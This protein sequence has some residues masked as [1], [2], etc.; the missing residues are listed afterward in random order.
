MLFIIYSAHWTAAPWQPSKRFGGLEAL[1][2]GRASQLGNDQR[3]KGSAAQMHSREAA[4][5]DPAVGP[6]SRSAV[7]PDQHQAPGSTP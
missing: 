5:P 6:E 3:R 2:R 1:L 7:D 4:Y